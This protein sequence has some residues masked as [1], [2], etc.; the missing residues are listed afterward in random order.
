M[1]RNTYSSG[2]VLAYGIIGLSTKVPKPIRKFP[3]TFWM[4]VARLIPSVWKIYKN[5]F[6]RF[7][8]LYSRISYSSFVISIVLGIYLDI[9]FVKVPRPRDSEVTFSVFE[10]H[11]YLFGLRVILVPD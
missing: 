11:C 1:Y 4:S 5:N 3:V 10:S 8:F 9:L 6:Y 7:C 2:T